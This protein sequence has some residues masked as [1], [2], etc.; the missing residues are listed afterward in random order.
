VPFTASHAAVAL[1]A[2][3]SPLPVAAMAAG[4]VAPDL[5]YFVPVPFP[6]ELSHS[7]L[8]AVTV[9]PLFGLAALALWWWMLRAPLVALAPVALRRR[10]PLP[11][12][13]IGSRARRTRGGIPAFVVLTVLATVLGV[14]T[15]L[16]WDWFTHPEGLAALWP[17]WGAPLGPLAAYKWAQHASSL[18]GL[19]VLAVA[20]VRAVRR[21]PARGRVDAAALPLGI[22]I[23]ALSSPVIAAGLGGLIRWIAGMASGIAPF[24]PALVFSVARVTIGAGGAVLALVVLIWWLAELRRRRSTAR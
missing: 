17:A 15:H 16:G 22:R 7:L 6:R 21:A 4:A 20:A 12:E 9:D 2:R 14:L 3:R 1:L 24:S 11:L 10:L 13:P 5:P 8:G 18:F 23:A 19:I